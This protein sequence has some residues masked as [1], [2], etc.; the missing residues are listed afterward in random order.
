MTT[1]CR[2]G[3]A[4]TLGIPPSA[5][6]EVMLDAILRTSNANR[7]VAVA[8][9]PDSFEAARGMVPLPVVMEYLRARSGSVLA[10]DAPAF[11]VCWRDTVRRSGGLARVSL[12]FAE[13]FGG[14]GGADPTDPWSSLVMVLAQMRKIAE[15]RLLNYG[16][17]WDQDLFRPSNENHGQL[18]PA[19]GAAATPLRDM[20]PWQMASAARE[21]GFRSVLQTTCRGSIMPDLTDRERTLVVTSGCGSIPAGWPDALALDYNFW[22]MVIVEMIVGPALASKMWQGI[23]NHGNNGLAG[24]YSDL[25]APSGSWASPALA[26]LITDGIVWVRPLL[27]YAMSILV[28]YSVLPL[29]MRRAMSLTGEETVRL[30]GAVGLAMNVLARIPEH[31]ATTPVGPY[32]VCGVGL[33][34]WSQPGVVPWE[35][36]HND[37]AVD[38]EDLYGTVSPFDWTVRR[39][40][41]IYGEGPTEPEPPPEVVFPPVPS[42]DPE[43]E[44]ARRKPKKAGVGWVLAGLGM[45][46]AGGFAWLRWGRRG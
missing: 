12:D 7:A 38:V 29:A 34:G 8:V 45:L 1:P 11:S 15:V 33:N 32:E 42:M 16:D 31:G 41:G 5:S 20:R 4:L 26:S 23:L 9:T 40:A 19:V 21:D 39:W 17:M 13:T 18:P 35:E 2:P 43:V 44:A 14:G 25:G 36:I 3:D 24:Y 10:G 37:R 6:S 27:S 22:G 28:A 46:V 30:E